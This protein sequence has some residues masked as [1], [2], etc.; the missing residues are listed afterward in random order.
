MKTKSNY[1]TAK[2]KA[3]KMLCNRSNVALKKYLS[4]GYFRKQ[5][6][7]RR[8]F[9]K[10]VFSEIKKLLKVLDFSEIAKKQKKRALNRIIEIPVNYLN[11]TLYLD[12]K[13]NKKDILRITDN[14]IQFRNGRNHYAKNQKDI[15]LL[16]ILKK[17]VNNGKTMQK[18]QPPVIRSNGR[19]KADQN[20]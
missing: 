17:Y 15:I 16:S 5:L 18:L 7:F 12:Y 1:Q 10:A 14:C 2:E 19:S 6:D 20:K 11:N 9:D 3:I 8:N 13:A 4:I